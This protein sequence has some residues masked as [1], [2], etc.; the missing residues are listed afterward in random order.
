MTILDPGSP[1][2]AVET[3]TKRYNDIPSSTLCTTQGTIEP[4]SLTSLSRTNE[5]TGAIV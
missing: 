2:S 1:I 4:D 3:G 5:N